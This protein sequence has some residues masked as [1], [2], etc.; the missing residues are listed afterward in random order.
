MKGMLVLFSV[1]ALLALPLSVWGVTLEL[2]L[3]DADTG[4]SSASYNPDTGLFGTGL[5]YVNIK[6]ILSHDFEPG[7]DAIQ[8]QLDVDNALSDAKWGMEA[9]PA[10][11]G[12][13]FTSGQYYYQLYNN[14]APGT[15]ES[16]NPQGA[17]I[18]FIQD[19]QTYLAP[20]TN[21]WVATYRVVPMG[22]FMLGETYEFSAIHSNYWPGYGVYEGDT[23][24]YSGGASLSV[25]I[26]PEPAIALLLMMALPLLS[27]RFST[28][29]NGSDLR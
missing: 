16:I 4:L 23:I 22:T 25:T 6:V 2:D 14:K 24:P 26:V 9:S 20:L 15:L 8:F 29:A 10:T 19:Y 21:G 1:M 3:V 11:N 13:V 27:R 28:R 12:T 17:E 18:F 7:L 5:P